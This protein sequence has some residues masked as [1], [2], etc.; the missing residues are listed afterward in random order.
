ML[1]LKQARILNRNAWMLMLLCSAF[2]SCDKTSST[3]DDYEGNWA[4]S[5]DFEGVARTEA[6][7]F[8]IGNYA[9]VGTGYKSTDVRLKDFWQFNASTGTW[10]QKADLPGIERNSAV[11]FA[12]G[13]KGYVGTGYDGVNKL[14]DFYEYDA[15]A[16]SWTPKADFGGSAR[17]DAIGFS[18]S[19]KGY[20]ATGYDD[21]YLKD[22]WQYNPSTNQWVQVSSLTGYKRK[23]AAVFVIDDLAYVCTGT[24]NGDNIND[25]WVYSGIDDKWTEKRKISDAND[26]EDY[27]DDYDDIVRDDAVAFVMNG[28]GYIT[29]GQSGGNISSTW[30]YTPS[31]DLWEQR[32]SFEGTSRI[33]A[34]A[35]TI[36]NVGYVATG[37]NSSYRFDDC[38]SFNP[39][40]DQTDDDN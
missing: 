15:D 8:T 16:N 33:G 5:S 39:K 2:Y 9:Y 28:K 18:V 29:C 19:A 6:V 34:V 11:G 17:Y 38:W 3:S 25:F 36:N 31:T 30:E 22:N 21:N 32:T 20:I 24:N 35:F 37:N 13:D 14:K 10:K 1:N 7:T 23:G 26:D 40:E 12:I 27:D 4:R